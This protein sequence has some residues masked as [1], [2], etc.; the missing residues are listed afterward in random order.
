MSIALASSL[1]VRLRRV[2]PFVQKS[3]EVTKPGLKSLKKGDD[4]VDLQFIECVEG[5]HVAFALPNDDAYG[6]IGGPR[7]MAIVILQSGA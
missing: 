1:S 6:V 4:I 5:G 7:L 3:T 2:C